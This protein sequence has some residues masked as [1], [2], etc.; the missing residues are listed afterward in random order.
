MRSPLSPTRTTARST[1]DLRRNFGHPYDVTCDAS[2]QVG[3][4][5]HEVGLDGSHNDDSENMASTNELGESEEI[6]ETELAAGQD[7]LWFL[8]EEQSKFY[9]SHAGDDENN[10]RDRDQDRDRGRSRSRRLPSDEPMDTAAAATAASLDRSD[11]HSD[12]HATQTRARAALARHRNPLSAGISPIDSNSPRSPAPPIYGRTVSGIYSILDV[13]SVFSDGTESV[14]DSV[15]TPHASALIDSMYAPLLTDPAEIVGQKT[16]TTILLPSSSKVEA[17]PMQIASP[18]VAAV[19]ATARA[20]SAST[21][22][23]EHL[24]TTSSDHKSA[25]HVELRPDSIPSS[26]KSSFSG[27]TRNHSIRTASDSDGSVTFPISPTST[28]VSIS[29][30]EAVARGIC[31]HCL[32]VKSPDQEHDQCVKRPARSAL[33]RTE[34]A[35]SIASRTSDRSH[36]ADTRSSK[37]EGTVVAVSDSVDHPANVDSTH[38]ADSATLKR[39]KRHALLAQDISDLTT[40][41]H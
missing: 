2:G 4:H 34:Q 13:D 33:R 38:S 15:A 10:E 22:S 3:A 30:E 23:S 39:S 37:D 18:S 36:S 32:G 7:P 25:S 11:R 24:S 28:T 29:I 9:A 5:M 21:A 14:R 16:G 1:P 19:G 26:F 40:S 17:T 12:D 8:I 20:S 31:L 6:E 35:H 41:A 27:S